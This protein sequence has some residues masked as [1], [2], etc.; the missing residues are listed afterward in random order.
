MRKRIALIH[1]VTVA[2]PP[3]SAAFAELWPE[4]E[5]VNLLDDSLPVDRAKADDLTPALHRRITGLATYARDLGADGVLFTCSAFGTAIEAAARAAAWPVLKPNE[6]MFEAALHAGRRIGMLA[7]FERSIPSMEQE[8]R[9]LVQA[10]G[11]D[12]T[13]RSVCVPAAM[14]ALQKGDAATHNA[15]LAEAAPQL[16][17][18]DAVM[19]AQFSTSVA[20]PAVQARVK[21]PV[22]TSPGSAVRKM[23]ALLRA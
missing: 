12:A 16:A 1:A 7:S 8:F 10:R 20:A 22:L 2:M 15:M 5:L 23:K 11:V 3:V 13:L 14:P 9:E 18:C 21:A 17:D 19:L 6:A 4:A